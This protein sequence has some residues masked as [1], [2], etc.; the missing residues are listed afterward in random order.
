MDTV[1]PFGLWSA[2]K[3][4]SAV[5]DAAQWVLVQRMEKSNS[6][7]YL[8]DFIL[9]SRQPKEA[10]AARQVL[11]STFRDLGIPLEPYS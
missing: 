11:E 4:F 1:L 8:D 2:P 9:V 5:A 7:H 6:L 10:K 3:I